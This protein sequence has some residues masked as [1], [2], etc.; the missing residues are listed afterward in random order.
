VTAS[1][2]AKDAERYLDGR[3]HALTK[4]KVNTAPAPCDTIRWRRPAIV[5]LRK[6]GIHV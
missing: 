1:L 2:P 5:D 4:G 3:A 6:L